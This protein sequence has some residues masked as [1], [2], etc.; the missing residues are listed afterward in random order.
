MLEHYA[1]EWRECHLSLL[2]RQHKTPTVFDRFAYSGQY[3]IGRIE[4]GRYRRG[5]SGRCLTD[6]GVAALA[7]VGTVATPPAQKS[8]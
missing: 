6:V 8:R 2:R 5:G 1:V 3:L 4:K 7:V